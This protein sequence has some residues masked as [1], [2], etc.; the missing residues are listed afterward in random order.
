MKNFFRNI[1]R[2]LYWLPII[3][4]DRDWDEHFFFVILQHKLK[5]MEKY[6]RKNAHFIGMEKEAKK[7]K[8]CVQILNRII[9]DNYLDL[10]FRQH[11]QKWGKLKLDFKGKL[12]NEVDIYRTKTTPE[13]KAQEAIESKQYHELEEY[14]RKQD[15]TYLFYLI[16]KY[17]RGWWD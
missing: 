15:L 4:K 11:E 9:D 1:K 12:K 3:W 5:S 10:A 17:I 16:N 2:L 13:T 14:L 8:I 6:F 7:I